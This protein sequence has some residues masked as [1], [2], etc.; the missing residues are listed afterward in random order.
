VAAR[1][2]ASRAVKL[3][4]GPE[5]E[6]RSGRERLNEDRGGSEPMTEL[7]AVRLR[8]AY[9]VADGCTAKNRWSTITTPTKRG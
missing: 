1:G 9:G 6:P 7:R 4:A 8:R 3:N 5:D 2:H